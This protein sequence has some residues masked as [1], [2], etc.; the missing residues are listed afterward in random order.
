LRRA[1]ETTRF[2]ADHFRGR[3]RLRGGATDRRC[4]APIF[5]GA[6]IEFFL[7]GSR[8]NIQT[9]PPGGVVGRKHSERQRAVRSNAFNKGKFCVLLPKILLPS[10]RPFIELATRAP[11][12]I[13]LKLVFHF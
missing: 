8:C 2:A 9:G 6:K 11:Q 12:A 5:D 4:S 3:R 13:Q 7:A 10:K 1:Q